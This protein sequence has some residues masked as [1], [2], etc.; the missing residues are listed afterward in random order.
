M[1]EI[2]KET[3][4]FSATQRVNYKQKFC[5]MTNGQATKMSARSFK[6]M[7]KKFRDPKLYYSMWGELPTH[8]CTRKVQCRK[9]PKEITICNMDELISTKDE[10]QGG[11][12]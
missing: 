1:K 3:E 9:P 5:P 8:M 7:C 11:I 2:E 12:K 6:K 10:Q 4:W